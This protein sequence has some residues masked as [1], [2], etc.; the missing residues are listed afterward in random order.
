MTRRPPR[1]PAAR[2][3]RACARARVVLHEVA[4]LEQRRRCRPAPSWLVSGEP[5]A[6]FVTRCRRGAAM[7]WCRSA[8]TA[9]G[10]RGAKRQPVGQAVGGGTE[11]EI[12]V[13]RSRG[14]VIV[15]TEPKRPRVYGC[16]GASNT[17]RVEARSTIWPAYITH[18]SSARPATTPRSW[19]IS[20]TAMPRCS[21]QAVEQFEDL[22]LHR[23]V[24]RGRRLVG[25]EYFGLRGER[26]GDHHPLAHAA[27]QLVRI[28]VEPSRRVGNADFRRAAP[29]RAHS[30]SLPGH[31][32]VRPHRFARSGPRR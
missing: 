9:P 8:R 21:A 12:G 4:H 13:S 23:H 30:A 16:A 22:G 25:D 1:A 28:L 18:M 15:G 7:A 31:R 17:C 2:S 6:R 20:S 26:D 19:V 27:A 24:E 3:G 14:P 32:P 5:A 29:P 11:P 10:Q